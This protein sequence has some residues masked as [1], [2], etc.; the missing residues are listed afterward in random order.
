MPMRYYDQKPKYSEDPEEIL[1]GEEL[2]EHYSFCAICFGQI[3]APILNGIW[4]H[5]R[6]SEDHE[7]IPAGN[8]LQL[9]RQYEH[10][11]KGTLLKIGRHD[12]KE[13]LACPCYLNWYKLLKKDVQAGFY[14]D[15][16]FDKNGTTL[17]KKFMLDLQGEP[18]TDPDYPEKQGYKCEECISIIEKQK[19]IKIIPYTGKS[20]NVIYNRIEW[21]KK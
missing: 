2:K 8:L 5:R 9:F 7:P 15:H 19:V 11:G 20:R 1:E 17:C 10:D 4:Y 13:E 21:L 14:G 12:D 16:Y 6:G 3:H 18:I